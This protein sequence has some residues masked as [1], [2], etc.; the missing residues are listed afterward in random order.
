MAPM[1][2]Y[3]WAT[4]FLEAH[5]DMGSRSPASKENLILALSFS[6]DRAACCSR[7]PVLR[8]FGILRMLPCLS[9]ELERS[10]LLPRSGDS[11]RESTP[12]IVSPGSYLVVVIAENCCMGAAKGVIAMKCGCIPSCSGALDFSITNCPAGSSMKRADCRSTWRLQ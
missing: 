6:I 10:S 11:L 3:N 7:L 12:S 4:R 2:L 9:S 1:G 8:F 5:L